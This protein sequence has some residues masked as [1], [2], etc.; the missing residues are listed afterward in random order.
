VISTLLHR[1]L[2][3]LFFVWLPGALLLSLSYK[4]TLLASLISVEQDE[5][6]DT[7]QELIDN[8]ITILMH[9]GLIFV[10]LMRESPN[11]VVRL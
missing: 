9:R 4:S 10:D 8:K 3:V 6:V 1:Y 2:T 11:S 7:W 5:A